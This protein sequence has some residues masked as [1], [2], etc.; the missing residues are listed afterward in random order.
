MRGDDR[1]LPHRRHGVHG[2]SRPAAVNRDNAYTANAGANMRELMARMGHSTARAAMIYLHSADQRQRALADAV[3]K[4]ARAELR[5][6]RRETARTRK[7]AGSA[8]ASGTEVA[9]GGENPS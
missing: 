6:A 9:R 3:D 5:R 1:P 8:S 2:L 7:S 4:A